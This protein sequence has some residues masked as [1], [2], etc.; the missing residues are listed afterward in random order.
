MPPVF[1]P[2]V[3]VV[4][5]L[6]VLRRRRAAAP[7]RRRRARTARPRALEQLLDH[8]RRRR[9][10]PPPRS[11]GV[12]LR[13]GP[14]DE[15]ALAGGEPV[16]LHARRAR[17]AT[18]APPRSARRPPPSRPSRTS[19][20]PRSA[21]PP[22]LGPKTAMPRVPQHVGDAGDERRLRPDDDEV[23][24]R[25][26]GRGASSP[27]PSSARTGWQRPSRAMPGFPG[28]ACSSSSRGLCASLHAS[29]CSRPPDPTRSTFTRR[30]YCGGGLASL[31]RMAEAPPYATARGRRRPRAGRRASRTSSP[32][33]SRS[34]SGSAAGRSR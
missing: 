2:R 10:P 32:S 21:R 4:E 23:D 14:A 7:A 27:S 24:R 5:P 6:E 31:P 25:A 15:D 16:G 28:A 30:V 26:R 20:T 1:G 22:A 11:A 12:E 33:R 9:A 8:E 29:A 19:S 34:R 3:A 13:L 17:R 18:G